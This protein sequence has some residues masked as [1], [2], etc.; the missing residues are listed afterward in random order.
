VRLVGYL[1]RN[2]ATCFVNLL[3]AII[4]CLEDYDLLGCN[5]VWA[6][7]GGEDDPKFFKMFSAVIFKD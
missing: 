3:S 6:G 5:P 7:G 4:L 2:I 1:K